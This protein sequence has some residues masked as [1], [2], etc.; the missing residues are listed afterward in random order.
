MLAITF[1]KFRL[2]TG[3]LALSAILIFWSGT[4]SADSLRFNVFLGSPPPVVVYHYPPV[5]YT[6]PVIIE[7]YE[8]YPVYHYHYRH[9]GPPDWAPA[10]GYWKKHWKHERWHWHHDD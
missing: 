4:A 3:F 6:E 2:L 9:G 10:Y 7:R 5:V 1:R 8:P